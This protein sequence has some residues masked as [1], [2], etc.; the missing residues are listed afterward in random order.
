MLH[1]HT[2]FESMNP[3]QVECTLSIL[4]KECFVGGQKAYKLDDGG[5]NIDAGENDI[6][7]YYDEDKETLNFICR[8]ERDRAFY[9]SKLMAFAT[10][11][12]INTTRFTSN[13]SKNKSF[14]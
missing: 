6:R 7:A 3:E 13:P 5:F 11:H 14:F 8:Y 12:G 4:A 1:C 2:T 9:D 10:N